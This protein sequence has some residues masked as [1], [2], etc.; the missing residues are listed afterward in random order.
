M[1]SKSIHFVELVDFDGY[2]KSEKLSFEGFTNKSILE[3]RVQPGER[4]VWAAR[5]SNSDGWVERV[6]K[7]RKLIYI[8]P[9]TQISFLAGQIYID[10]E[11]RT[12]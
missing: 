4:I 2:A 6:I 9:G 7:F 1:N 8:G 11:G 10:P 3:F 5:I 12:L